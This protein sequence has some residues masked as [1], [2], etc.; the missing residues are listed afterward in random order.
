MSSSGHGLHALTLG[1]EDIS[2]PGG[3]TS[4]RRESY[5]PQLDNMIKKQLG[6]LQ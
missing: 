3:A 6:K 2:S 1:T 4:G 5:N